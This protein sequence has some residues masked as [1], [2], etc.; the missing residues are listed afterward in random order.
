MNFVINFVCHYSIIIF[1]LINLIIENVHYFPTTS[2]RAKLLFLFIII[3]KS[4]RII[5]EAKK[6]KGENWEVWW[7][8]LLTFGRSRLKIIYIYI[9]IRRSCINTSQET[10]QRLWKMKIVLLLKYK[11]LKLFDWCYLIMLHSILQKKRPQRVLWR[12]FLICIKNRPPQIK[13]IWWSDYSICRWQKAHW[14]L[15]ISMNLI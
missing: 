1:F 9:Y 8:K 4:R 13:F 7:W 5:F 2:I 10:K 12:L 6:M 15:N 3:K 14:E 11:L